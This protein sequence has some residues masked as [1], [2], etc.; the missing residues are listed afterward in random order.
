MICLVCCGGVSGIGV[1]LL[2]YCSMVLMR[3][4]GSITD[5]AHDERIDVPA[6]T[7]PCFSLIC[8][9]SD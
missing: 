3:G 4:V 2:S 1:S 6:T 7:V 5:V 8:V 9:S